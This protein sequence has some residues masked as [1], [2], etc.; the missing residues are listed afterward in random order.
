MLLPA[1]QLLGGG[2]RFW[3]DQLFCKPGRR[4]GRCRLASRLFLL[5]AYQADGAPH[6]LDRSRRFDPRKRLS[7]LC[8]KIAQ[9][10]AAADHQ[11]RRAAW[12]QSKRYSTRSNSSN[13]SRSP[14]RCPPGTRAFHH[15]LTLHGSYENRSKRPRRAVVINPFLDGVASDQDEPLMPGTASHRTRRKDG[16][17]ISPTA[18]WG[19]VPSTLAPSATTNAH[20][21]HF[22]TSPCQQKNYRPALACL[23]ATVLSCLL[24]CL[25]GNRARLL[26][27][28]RG[29]EPPPTCVDM[30]LNHARLPIPPLGPSVASSLAKHPQICKRNVVPKRKSPCNSRR[31]TS[32]RRTQRI[33][34]GNTAYLQHRCRHIG[35]A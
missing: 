27:P 16:R 25:E 5:D 21:A 32:R 19:L 35:E 30:D 18:V 28:E 26:V 4:R 12:R 15:P 10:A 24:A 13:S 7:P 29:F 17:T 31:A 14:A 23:G 1:S 20:Q 3:H 22:L 11:S 2:V 34:F 9:V 33:S 8:A 6:L